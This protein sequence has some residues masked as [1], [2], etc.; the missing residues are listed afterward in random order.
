MKT[1]HSSSSKETQKLG[2]ALAKKLLKKRKRALVIALSGG[3][4]AGKTTFAQGFLKG[5]GLN[6]RAQS[7]TFIIMRR[8]RLA[9]RSKSSSGWRFANVFHVDAYRLKEAK[10]L[11]ELGF[12]DIAADPHNVI[13]LE[14]PER[15]KKVVP[16]DALWIS[17][18]Y[19]KQAHERTITY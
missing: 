7:P 19:G 6:K 9:Q 14:W 17:F 8:H 13:L 15:A 2:E 16:K 4:G 3:L 10:H 18:E 1:Y 12:K 11:G 5:V